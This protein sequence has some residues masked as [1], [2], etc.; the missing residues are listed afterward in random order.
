MKPALT[1]EEWENAKGE[2]VQFGNASV[3]LWRTGGTLSVEPVNEDAGMHLEPS[4]RHGLAALAL[5]GQPFGF[6]REDVEEIRAAGPIGGILYSIADRIEALL[7][8]ELPDI[9]DASFWQLNDDLAP[10]PPEG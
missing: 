10:T 3:I 7:P 2:G 4:Q 5:S 9:G 1:A 8:P 6:T